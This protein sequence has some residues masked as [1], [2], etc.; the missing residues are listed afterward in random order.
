MSH[1]CFCPNHQKG[2]VAWEKTFK[3]AFELSS[4]YKHSQNG[5]FKRKPVVTTTVQTLSVPNR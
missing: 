3:K 4:Q 2:D 1:C 5:I